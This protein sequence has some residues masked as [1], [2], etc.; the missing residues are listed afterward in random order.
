MVRRL[1]LETKTYYFSAVSNEDFSPTHDFR[2]P[3]LE[4]MHDGSG[5][6]DGVVHLCNT[7]QKDLLWKPCTNEFKLL[8]PSQVVRPPHASYCS[9]GCRGFGLDA[10]SG[11]YKLLRFVDIVFVDKD[12]YYL[13]TDQLI[14]LY[15]LRS[16]SWKEISDRPLPNDDYVYLCSSCCAYVDG[17]Y[18]WG[19]G[20]NENVRYAKSVISFDFGTESFSS[21]PMPQDP[22]YELLGRRQDY[23]SNLVEFDGSLGVIVF[24]RSGDVK[25]FV[26]WVLNKE[27]KKESQWSRKFEIEIP[28]ADRPLNFSGDGGLLFLQGSGRHLLVYD[29]KVGK[30]TKCGGDIYEYL[31]QEQYPIHFIPYLHTAAASLSPNANYTDDL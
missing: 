16:D 10:K 14:E 7:G 30:L 18:Y 29:L 25:T 1:C 5:S 8:P 27:K 19:S 26:L 13:R 4:W 20:W 28:G 21:F 17:C 6:C 11:D 3:Y 31:P 24:P 9:Y 2:S 15:S 23:F 12:D 22:K